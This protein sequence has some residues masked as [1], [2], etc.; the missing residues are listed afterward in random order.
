MAFVVRKPG[1]NITEAEIMDFIAKQA[2]SLVSIYKVKK[3]IV[4]TCN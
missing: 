4:V 2:C 3:F 1:S